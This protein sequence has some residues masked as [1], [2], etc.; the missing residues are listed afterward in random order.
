[1]KAITKAVIAA[2]A[3]AL[4]A[5]AQ[6]AVN[7]DN[8]GAPTMGTGAGELFLSVVDRGGPI[9]RSYILDLGISSHDFLVNDASYVN[10]LSI[11]ADANLLD[12]INNASGSLYWNLAANHNTFENMNDW[13]YL[14][15]APSFITNPPPGFNPIAESISRI[16]TY[17]NSVNGIG[18]TDVSVNNS[19]IFTSLD[20]AFYGGPLWRN[21]W[22]AV[23][24]TEG[25][26]GTDLG[27]YFVA[28]DFDADPDTGTMSWVR[29]LAGVWNL[30]TDGVLSYVGVGAPVPVP[31]AVW[32]L[33]SALI[34]LVGVARRKSEIE[35]GL[36][37]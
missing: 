21:S 22:N 33:G 29:E 34:G 36:A 8:G 35:G 16:D 4:G 31:A 30:S 3:L 37:A 14:T 1:M 19:K 6:A 2:G 15:T 20:N 12:I 11:T 17:L 10:N 23:H 27:F 28:L 5:Q 26:I 13:G 9:E 24:E 18:D 7:S 25:A 32:L